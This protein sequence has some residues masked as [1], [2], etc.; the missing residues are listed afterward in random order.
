[1]CERYSLHRRPVL[2]SGEVLQADTAGQFCCTGEVCAQLEEHR[3]KADNGWTGV[4]GGGWRGGAGLPG[5]IARCGRRVEWIESGWMHRG[6]AT[7]S[8]G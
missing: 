1:M 7:A 4:V 6:R 2:H 8:E 5:G 3:S